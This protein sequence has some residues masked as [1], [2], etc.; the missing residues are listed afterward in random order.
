TY[1]SNTLTSLLKLIQP[2]LPYPL[3]LNASLKFLL[4]PLLFILLGN[5][6]ST[7]QSYL[8]LLPLSSN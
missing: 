3:L 4:I 7:P 8:S 1:D 2:P 5:G 6:H